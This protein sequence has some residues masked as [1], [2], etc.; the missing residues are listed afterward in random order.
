MSLSSCSVNALPPSSLFKRQEQKSVSGAQF[1][2]E[3]QFLFLGLLLSHILWTQDLLHS[4]FTNKTT[5][6]HSFQMRFS[7]TSFVLMFIANKIQLLTNIDIEVQ[8]S[9]T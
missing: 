6:L 5:W 7:G 9:I 4:G 8:T 1:T 2:L 3:K